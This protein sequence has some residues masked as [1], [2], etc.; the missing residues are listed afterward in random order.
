MNEPEKYEAIIDA[1]VKHAAANTIDCSDLDA[2]T[3]LWFVENG[4][5]TAR[6]ISRAEMLIDFPAPEKLP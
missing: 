1:I 2:V 3:K 4:G 5:I 6:K